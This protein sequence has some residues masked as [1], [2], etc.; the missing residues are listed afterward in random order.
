[1]SHNY[2]LSLSPHYTLSLSSIGICLLTWNTP[3]TAPRHQQH[4]PSS[5]VDDRTTIDNTNGIHLEVVSPGEEIEEHGEWVEDDLEQ[6][7]VSVGVGG[8]EE[9]DAPYWGSGGGGGGEGMF[10]LL[11]GF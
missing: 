11:E 1:M 7:D 4:S 5:H 3:V 2:L 6:N 8:G 10:E 9:W